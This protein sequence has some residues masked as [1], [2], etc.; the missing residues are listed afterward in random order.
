MATAIENTIRDFTPLS[1][2]RSS[3]YRMEGTDDM[4]TSWLVSDFYWRDDVSDLEDQEV[5][6][7]ANAQVINDT[8]Q[9]VDPDQEDYDVI[10][11]RTMYGVTNFYVV[12]PDSKAHEALAEALCA[13]SDYPV[14][15]DESVTSCENCHRLVLTDESFGDSGIYCSQ[16]CADECEGSEDSE[17]SE[18]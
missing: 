16:H 18:D 10:S 11:S 7:K 9:R 8:L 2:W 4:D 12:K 6:N 17:D 3:N 15:C 1:D 13:I 14:L 5:L